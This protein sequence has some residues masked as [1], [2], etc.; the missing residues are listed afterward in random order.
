MMDKND[1]L[2]EKGVK[3]SVEIMRFMENKIYEIFQGPQKTIDIIN[4]LIRILTT[5][6]CYFIMDMTEQF[7]L[8]E[9]DSIDFVTQFSKL[10]GI[11]AF[12]ECLKVIKEN[13]TC[14]ECKKDKTIH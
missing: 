3:V 5:I 4:I 11:N 1:E 13:H 6:N 12:K 14:D 10:L 2:L 7:S 8:D 9:N